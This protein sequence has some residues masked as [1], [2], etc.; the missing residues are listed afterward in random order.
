MFLSENT[1]QDHLKSIFAKTGT[2]SRRAL[3]SRALGTG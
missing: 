3:L 1:V 2:R